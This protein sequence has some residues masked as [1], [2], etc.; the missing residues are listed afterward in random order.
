M[1]PW[2]ES[3]NLIIEIHGYLTSHRHDHCFPFECS[4][5]F[6]KVLDDIPRDIS[7][8]IR[9]TDDRIDLSIAPL[10]GLDLLRSGTLDLRDEMFDLA[11]DLFV[12]LDLHE[13]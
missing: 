9:M 13:S 1:P 11:Y 12:H 7:D 5:A 8:S 10:R 3:D 6:L 4:I 2:T